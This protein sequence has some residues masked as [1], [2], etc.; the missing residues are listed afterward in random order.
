MQQ[1]MEYVYEMYRQG[2]IMKAAEKLFISQ[3]A[4]S[5]SIR[6]TESELGMPLF[7]RSTRPMQLT[8][9]GRIYIESI[10]KMRRLELEL[11]DRLDD[12]SEL[13]GGTLRVGGS[14]YIIGRILGPVLTRFHRLYP[15]VRVELTENSSA[16]LS[17]LLK[18]RRIDLTLSCNED[19]IRDFER[20]PAFQDRILLAVPSCHPVCGE[21]DAEALSAADILSGKHLQNNCPKINLEAFKGL[22]YILLEEGNNLHDRSVRLFQEAGISPQISLSLAQLA[23]AF[24]LAANGFGATLTCDRMVTSPEVPLTFYL[25]DSRITERQFYFLFPNTDYTPKAIREFIRLFQER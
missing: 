7:D 3:P 17:D 24:Q 13:R 14:H 10:E 1:E 19:L 11:K 4:L 15:G 12:L 22:E 8:E 18:E 5:M 21:H 16:V 9:A 2:N 23:T 20:F 6:K 25:P